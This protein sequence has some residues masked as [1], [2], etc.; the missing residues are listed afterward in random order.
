M[1]SW[2]VPEAAEAQ[3]VLVMAAHMPPPLKWSTEAHVPCVMV[4]VYTGWLL[5]WSTSYLIC[6]IGI[7]V[8]SKVRCVLYWKLYDTWWREAM[9][10]FSGLLAFMRGIHR[11]PV[12]SPHKGQ[13][14]GALMFSFV[15]VNNRETGYLRRHRV[16]YDVIVMCTFTHVLV[17]WHRNFLSDIHYIYVIEHTMQLLIKTWEIFAEK[18]SE[19]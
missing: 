14:R 15:C 18:M 1:P 19:Y 6:L 2:W 17:Y 13:W 7:Y 3:S 5:S 8:D 9:E 4:G 10:K 12:N 16:H 11:S